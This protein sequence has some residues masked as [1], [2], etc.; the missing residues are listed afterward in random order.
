MSN[1]K[2]EAC[3]VDLKDNDDLFLCQACREVYWDY[4]DEAEAEVP[5]GVDADF[6]TINLDDTR[7]WDPE[8]E[9]PT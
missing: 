2:C 8:D 1:W 3:Q 5:S 7:H 6:D 4:I 9:D